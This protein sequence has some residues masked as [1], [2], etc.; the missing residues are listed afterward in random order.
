[1]L[2]ILEEIAQPSIVR[3]MGIDR[4]VAAHIFEKV[5]IA[6]QV[7]ISNQLLTFL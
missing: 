2:L 4:L 5:T 6:N 7:L 3:G 1:M